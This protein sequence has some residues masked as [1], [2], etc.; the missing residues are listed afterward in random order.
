MRYDTL[1]VDPFKDMMVQV[2]S[3]IP[4]LVIALGIFIIGWV[5]FKTV[6]VLLTKVLTT[7]GF[8]YVADKLGISSF[9]RTGGL[10]H[11]PSELISC[12]TYWVGMVMVLIMAVKSLG[13]VFASDLVDSVLSY[14][15]SVISGVLVLIVGM[16]MARFV[17]IVVYVTAKN[18]DM[19][20][21][22]TLSR[23]SKLAIMVYVTIIFLR[24]IGF[25]SLF[26]DTNYNLL[27]VGLI[28][29]LALAFG[30]AGKDVAAKYLDVFKA[31]KVSHK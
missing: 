27:F 5:V 26:T 25:E 3:F 1:I 14:V 22:A 8:D 23:L 16:L 6:R 19:P 11:K 4:T 30:L 28:F 20:A 15:P 7:I 29:S 12:L 10:R 21:P 9:L 13:L 2:T 24:E 31:K 18:T 17:S